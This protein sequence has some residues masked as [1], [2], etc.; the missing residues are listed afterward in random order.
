MAL[1]AV[2]DHPKFN[3]LKALLKANKCLTLGYLEGLWHFTGRF[4]P[5]G[6]IT[7]GGKYTVEDIEAWLEWDGEDGALIAAM[8]K[9]RWID[10]DPVHGLIVHDWHVHADDATKLALKRKEIPFCIPTLSQ[11]DRRCPDTVAQMSQPVRHCPDTVATVSRR[12]PDSIPTPSGLPEP[13]P[14]PVPEFRIHEI[15]NNSA[16][17]KFPEG[18]NNYYR[19]DGFQKLADIDPEGMIPEEVA[20]GIPP[21]P[22]QRRKA[23]EDFASQRGNPEP[24]EPDSEFGSRIPP[25]PV[26]TAAEGR[27]SETQARLDEQLRKLR[28]VAS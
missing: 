15:K 17:P 14:G 5:D 11:P 18:S 10:E 22:E 8:V 3:R 12:C 21:E 7:A 2:L 16:I 24:E 9:A 25:P 27:D 23:P 4:T 1:R 19:A 6:N 13:E 20:L 26:V 28:G